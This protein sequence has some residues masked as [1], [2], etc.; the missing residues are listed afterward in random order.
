[1]TPR[2]TR[3]GLAAPMGAGIDVEKIEGETRALTEE[4]RVRNSAKS[5]IELSRAL[6]RLA[7]VLS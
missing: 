3:T 2:L 6:Q 7:G 4:V 5:A 1:M